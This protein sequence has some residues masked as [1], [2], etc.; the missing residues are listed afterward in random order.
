VPAADCENAAP[1][2]HTCNVQTKTNLR[3]NIRDYY[4]SFARPMQNRRARLLSH[5]WPDLL[6][7]LESPSRDGANKK[8]CGESGIRVENN[9]SLRVQSA[10]IVYEFDFWGGRQKKSGVL[11]GRNYLIHESPDGRG[12]R[13]IKPK[14]NWYFTCA[15]GRG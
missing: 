5:T 6:M 14:P 9:L 3:R 8:G 12:F 1:A 11:L 2:R 13:W 10:H 4:L 7:E 15:K